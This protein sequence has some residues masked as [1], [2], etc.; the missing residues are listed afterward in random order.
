MK[1]GTA[2]HWFR[3]DLR[4]SDNPALD[5]AAQYETLIPI[6]IL[7]E[8]NSG[9]FKMGAASKWW[10]HQSL[11]KLN[12][13]LDGKLLVYQGNPH[14]I[15]NKLIEEQEVSY[16]TWNRCYEPWRI[17]RDKEI[18][19][20][21]EDKN[22]AV[23]SFSASLLWEPWTI[24]KD[25]GTPYRVFT[26]FYKKGCLNSEEPRL[27]AG[28]VDL[29]N[30][31]SEDL[32]SDSITDLN[33][34]PTIKWYKSFEEEWNPGEIGAEQ[35]LN[36][37]LDSGLLNYKE[38]RNFPSQ[39]FVS[40][41]SPHL[42]FGEISP[43]EVWY[44]AKTKE[45]ISG[46]EKSLAHFHSELGWREFSYY[47]LYHFPDLPNK[48]FQEKFDIFPWQENEEFLALWQKGNTGYPI[49]D[50]GMRELWQTGYMHNRLRMIVGSFLVKNLLIDWRF[51]ERWFWDCLVD[52][53]LASNSA[54]WQ[55]VAGSG[56]DA[57]P[58]FRIFNPI[59]QGLKFDPEGEYTKKY[60][61]ELRDLPN[62]YLF[63][64][65]EA[66]ENILADAGIELGKNYPK[67]MVD[68]KLS[69]ETALEAFAT[70]KK[71]NNE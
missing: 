44:R 33:L 18:K 32:S 11:T 28:K 61:P 27:P 23:E 40:R 53:D 55:W 26:P 50:A 41:L 8:V 60:V 62:K 71:E 10:L 4:L 37:F 66:P 9:E 65:W 56:A 15:L 14:E 16:V 24:S 25:D 17:D 19:R 47:L 43:N 2:I 39:E 30:L 46:I 6:Y 59:T 21:F 34:L 35:N 49:V 42:H 1:K 12:E 3:Q 36:S 13:S 63:S 29:S 45:G 54:S 51:G 69:R 48:N 67:P 68:L 57:A 31:Y 70:T 20:N 64:P 38:G 58:Y 22:L 7:D 5:S 52:A